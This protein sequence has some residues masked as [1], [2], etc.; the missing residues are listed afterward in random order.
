[1][2]RKKKEVVAQEIAQ[3]V[4]RD[5]TIYHY[6]DLERKVDVQSKIVFKRQDKFI[7]YPFYHDRETGVTGS[8]YR[9]I[10]TFTFEGLKGHLPLG[11]ITHA[12]RGYGVAR[13][14]KPLIRFVEQNFDV[15][16]ITISKKDKSSCTR[17]RLVIS[18]RD[19]ENIRNPL[20]SIRRVFI[21]WRYTDGKR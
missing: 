19:F 7:L 15:E 10:R 8:K 6:V 17:N 12:S 3:K 11:F 5:R 2:A 14:L 13:G 16:D 9:K 21:C 4:T 20:N 1:M 18:F